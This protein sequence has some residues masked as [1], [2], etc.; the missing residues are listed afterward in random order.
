MA[1]TGKL[2]TLDTKT[3]LNVRKITVKRKS[4]SSGFSAYPDGSSWSN[5]ME[6]KT[7]KKITKN[8]DEK[9]ISTES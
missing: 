6:A 1:V 5:K 4:L 3:D 2:R 8:K 7:A 9:K